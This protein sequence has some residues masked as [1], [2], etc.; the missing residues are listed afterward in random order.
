MVRGQNE[1]S[2]STYYS[3]DD[4]MDA[5]RRAGSHF[6]DADTM[7]FFK[8][9]VSPQAYAGRLGFLYFLTS[10]RNLDQPREYSVR[11]FDP[12]QPAGIETVG[13]FGQYTTSAAAH[14][15][16][17]TMAEWSRQQAA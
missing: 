3:T 17:R 1:D 9:R 12:E 7:R 15:A 11:L 16:A 6:F 4:I 5:N 10:E 14:K 13:E 8:S 2:V